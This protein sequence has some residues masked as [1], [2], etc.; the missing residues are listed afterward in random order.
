MC[1]GGFISGILFF[2]SFVFF[3]N[4]RKPM[5]AIVSQYKKKGISTTPL[6]CALNR[7]IFALKDSGA[8]F[9]ALLI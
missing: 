2:S 1:L 5:W 9:D 3:W 6:S 7:L 4:S 8:A